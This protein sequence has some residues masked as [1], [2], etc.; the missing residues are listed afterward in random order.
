MESAT[1]KWKELREKI[2]SSSSGNELFRG[3]T[4]VYEELEAAH[5]TIKAL[6]N[7]VAGIFDNPDYLEWLNEA[8]L[9]EYTSSTPAEIFRKLCM[10]RAIVKQKDKH[11]EKLQQEK[12]E[13]VAQE[14]RWVQLDV[15]RTIPEGTLLSICRWVGPGETDVH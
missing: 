4:E 14:G 10:V 1:V 7:R 6:A 15:G 12:V 5:R 3:F 13:P 11:I 8:D 9:E 2:Q